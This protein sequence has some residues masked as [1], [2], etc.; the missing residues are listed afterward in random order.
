MSVYGI[1]V[2][3]WR[4]EVRWAVVAG[5]G[6]QYAFCKATEGVGYED[7]RFKRNYEGIRDSG[8]F[9]GAFHYARVSRSP[10]LVDDAR[11]EADWFLKTVGE[12]RISTFPPCLDIEWDR[13]ARGIPAEELIEWCLAWL[14]QV[15]EALG[16][17][18]I[19]Y[20]GRNFW[21]YKLGRTDALYR[22]PLWLAQ[23]K[24]RK[25]LGVSRPMYEI[26]G[27]PWLFWQFSSKG[28]V[29]GVDGPCDVNVF[30]GTAQKLRSYVGDQTYQRR[31]HP[32][33]WTYKPS[34]GFERLICWV[35]S[36]IANKPV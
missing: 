35:A 15:E 16:V 18:P 17:I 32:E 10:T 2:S 23:Y 13:K 28:K 8:M 26:S 12:D 3:H 27:W 36:M 9:R 33:E 4:G 24:E 7:P 31:P 29:K 6:A 1:D 22:Y 19:V 25:V 20:T 34:D 11:R 30:S 5:H 14:H 21:V